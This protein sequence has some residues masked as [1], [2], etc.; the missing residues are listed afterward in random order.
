MRGEQR[1][2]QGEKQGHDHGHDSGND[3]CL[4]PEM[5]EH[6]KRANVKVGARR[7]D[8]IV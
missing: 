1:E 3:D 4:F 6:C 7:E 2:I 5:K 8:V